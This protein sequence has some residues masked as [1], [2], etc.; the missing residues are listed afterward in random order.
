MTSKKSA[1]IVIAATVVVTLLMLYGNVMVKRG[2]IVDNSILDGNDLYARMDREVKGLAP[3][4]FVSS[5][6]MTFVVPFEGRLSAAGLAKVKDLTDALKERFPE[7]GVMSL[8]TVPRYRDS[9]RELENAPY[10]T[11]ETIR[12]MG[13]DDAGKVLEEWKDAV[14]K[15]PA[16]YGPFVGRQFDHAQVVMLLPPDYDEIGVFRKV[17][18]FLEDRTIPACEWFVK[19]DI[20]PAGKFKGVLLAGWVAARGLM[21]AALLSDIMKLST[22]GLVI[23]AVAFFLSLRSVGQAAIASFTILLGFLWIRGSVGLLQ[24]MGFELYERVYFLLVFTAMIVSGISFAERKFES[25]NE[26]REKTPAERRDV[27][28]RR[29]GHVNEM[30]LLCG[31]I[32]ILNFATLYQIGV[33]GILE[34]GIFSAL[35][36]AYLLFFSLVFVP[37]VHA[38][39]GGIASMREPSWLSKRFMDAWDRFLSAVIRFIYGTF[40]R[41]DTRAKR[42]RLALKA[43]TVL[44]VVSVAAVAVIGLDV[45]PGFKKDFRF[46]EVRTKPME[47]IPNTI[48]D[49]ASKILNAPDNYGFDRVSVLVRPRTSSHET[50]P[51]TDPAFI[52]RVD[53][54]QRRFAE[55]TSARSVNSIVDTMK[56]ISRES[57]GMTLPATYRQA[58]DS[59]RL[60]R[61]DLGDTTANQL[62]FNGGATV[63]LSKASEDSNLLTDLCEEIRKVAGEFQD[64]DIS[65]FGKLGLYQ[66]SDKYIREGKPLNVLTSQWIVIVVCWF[67]VAWRSRRAAASIRL[68]GFRTGLV[69]NV[70][71]VF[72]SAAIVFVMVILRVPLD[73]ATACMTALAINAAV[74]FGLYLVADY[75]RALHEGGDEQGALRHALREKGKIILIDIVLNALCFAPL[76]TSRFIP[77]AR[78]GWIMI[79]MLIFCGIGALV[80]M[81]ALLPW[82]VKKEQTE[83][84]VSPSL[85]EREMRI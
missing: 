3:Q 85:M 57:Y 58:A 26:E 78:L 33:R 62:F 83:T 75:Q 47:Y 43:L 63:Y 34:V 27:L 29:T 84:A 80:L 2:G 24:L 51:M 20:V 52:A 42:R 17:A 25:F 10:I 61:W 6:A 71:F 36:I 56:Q 50:A 28:W 69:C 9:G 40:E 12:S 68:S 82:C 55:G 54:L 44:C 76:M 49:R 66:R 31:V 19:D 23:V 32:S 60:I 37:A 77:V 35:G 14:K 53:R 74:D 81:P 21:D 15:D 45:L 46:I 38:L 39:T 79:V 1:W 64:L 30:V 11:G 73:Q 5:D 41:A 48:V 72:A 59:L 13:S 8:S 65:I 4:G 70:P 67:W 7:C 16:I 22:V 18:E